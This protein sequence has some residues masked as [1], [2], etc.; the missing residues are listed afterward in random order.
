VILVLP[1]PAQ[2][3]PGDNVELL[4]AGDD[5]AWDAALLEGAVA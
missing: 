4:V 5:A 1:T 2:I 3:G